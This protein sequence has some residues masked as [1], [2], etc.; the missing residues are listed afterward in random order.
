MSRILKRIL[1]ST[2]VAGLVATPAAFATNGMFMIGYGA[3]MNAVGGAAI[4]L[5]QDALAGG[6]NPATIAY[7]PTRFDI[8]G[9]FFQPQVSAR[10]G[11]LHQDSHASHSED[12]SF[13][14]IPNLGFTYVPDTGRLA[15]GFSFVP[16]GGGGSRYEQNLYNANSQ[17]NPSPDQVNKPVGV[18]LVVAHMNP[19]IA[20]RLSDTQTVG[21][22][23]VIGVQM[24]RAIGLGYFT[25]FSQQFEDTGSSPGLTDNGN[26]WSYG[27]GLRLGWMGEFF[28]G[29]LRLGATGSTRVDMARFEK[30]EDLFAEQGNLDTPGS[31]GVGLAVK[32]FDSLTIALDVMRIFYSGVKSISNNG[33]GITG[34]TLF[35]TSKA[36]NGIGADAGLGFGWDDTWVVKLGAVYNLSRQF[37]FRAGWNYG[38]SPIREESQLLFNIV[39]P[40]TVQHH[41]TVGATYRLKEEGWF[42]IKD[43]ELSAV[44]QY[45]FRY[46]QSGPTYVGDTADI[47]MRQNVFG[48]EYGAYF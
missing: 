22:S 42:G 23:L 43:Q 39:A 27:L 38:E 18:N 12:F 20:L 33:P 14:I 16:V 47:Q 13:F 28:D 19:T 4:A 36:V 45:A 10:L 24:F 26:D 40:A 6:I 11:D 34:P 17:P 25:T 44:Y 2:A 32:P 48:M 3:K 15:Y 30:Y 21:A 35:E 29:R 1:I 5:P 46:T 7:V 41:F 37:A 9:D 8:G 31:A